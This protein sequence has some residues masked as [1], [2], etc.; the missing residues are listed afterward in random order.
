MMQFNDA[1]AWCDAVPEELVESFEKAA[2]QGQWDDHGGGYWYWD[3][4]KDIWWTYDTPT[5][6]RIKFREIVQQRH[7]GGVFAWGLGEDGP[8]YSHL[9]A[10]NEGIV[11]IGRSGRPVRNEL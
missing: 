1:F 4:E 9:D 5:A 6:I 3:E 7:V 10:V 11:D 8:E 2:T